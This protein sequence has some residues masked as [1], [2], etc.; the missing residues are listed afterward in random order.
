VVWSARFPSELGASRRGNVVGLCERHLLLLL[1][2]LSEAWANS[3]SGSWFDIFLESKT[4]SHLEIIKYCLNYVTQGNEKSRGVN[5]TSRAMARS[6]Q[7]PVGV[8]GL[9]CF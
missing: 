2:W 3:A 9:G 1:W 8:P 7:V 4:G 5:M 6:N